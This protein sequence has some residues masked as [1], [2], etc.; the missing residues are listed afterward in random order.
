MLCKYDDDVEDER[1][2]FRSELTSQ[3]AAHSNAEC[4]LADTEALCR[5]VTVIGKVQVQTRAGV[6]SGQ[7]SL[8]YVIGTNNHRSKSFPH[9]S[10]ENIYFI[11]FNNS[12]KIII[13]KILRIKNNK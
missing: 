6:V 2:S 1:I 3:G 5:I 8:L 4:R 12:L 11:Y 9:D 10:K 13:S 7:L